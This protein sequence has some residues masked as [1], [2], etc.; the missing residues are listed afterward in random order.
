MLVVE[1]TIRVKEDAE[2]T[3]TNEGG[4]RRRGSLRQRP[5]Q[6]KNDDVEVEGQSL[7]LMEEEEVNDEQKPLYAGHVVAVIER[8]PGQM[9]SG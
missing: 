1:V 7:L 4:L 3:A 8:V 2:Q 6:K 9:F 5:T